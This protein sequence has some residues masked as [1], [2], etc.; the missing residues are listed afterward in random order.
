MANLGVVY[1][2]AL[3]MFTLGM[4]YSIITPLILPFTTLYFGIAYLVY[5]YKFLFVYCE[6][7]MSVL[8]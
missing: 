2:Q 5:K 1:P 8:S 3:L 6:L 4:T 7:F